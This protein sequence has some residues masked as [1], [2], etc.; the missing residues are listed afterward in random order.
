MLM[1][2]NR[3]IKKLGHGL[4]II[5]LL[6]FAI[7]LPV[8]AESIPTYTEEQKSDAT[9][10]VKKQLIDRNTSFSLILDLGDKEINLSDNEVTQLKSVGTDDNRFNSMVSRMVDSHLDEV[11]FGWTL[12]SAAT[13]HTGICREG[14]Y[15]KNSING[16][17][18]YTYSKS[19]TITSDCKKIT[20]DS[21]VFNFYFD[22]YTT[23]AEE[24]TFETRAAEVNSNL[25]VSKPSKL[26]DYEK[27]CNIYNYITKNVAY[28]TANVNNDSYKIK[29]SAYAA[30]VNKT[31]VCQGYAS[32]FYYMALDAGLDCRI[33]KGFSKNSKGINEFHAWNLVKIENNYY[34]VDATWDSGREEYKY[35][36]EGKKSNNY[37]DHIL[38][39]LDV[40]SEGNDYEN[41]EN[42]YTIPD[43]SYYSGKT[44]TE[45][46][47]ATVTIKNATYDNGICNADVTV[48][49]NGKTLVRGIDYRVEFVEYTHEAGKTEGI[50][51]VNIT[52]IGMYQS[53]MGNIECK[54]V[55]KSAS[56]S[57]TGKNDENKT[58]TTTDTTTKTT[59]KTTDESTTKSSTDTA[60]KNEE[61]KAS[62]N[63]TTKTV[64]KVNDSNII[65][66]TF[67]QEIKKGYTLSIGQYKYKVTKAGKK[68]TLRFLGSKT[69]SKMVTVPDA[70]NIDGVEY[71]VTEI[72][73]KAF[74]GNTKMTTL[75]VGKNVKKIGS[76][77]FYG[78]K[79]L[80]KITIRSKSLK[81]VGSKAFKNIKNKAKIIVPKGKLTKYKKLLKKKGVS[82][83]A[84]FTT[85]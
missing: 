64:A 47:N 41:P 39:G 67:D 61:N 15:L 42:I 35:F 17:Y 68:G 16:E 49:M 1:E 40:M 65:Y 63:E 30:L 76:K 70:V 84:K 27:V 55:D 36:L 22:Y 11:N 37:S 81:S 31:A 78:C 57:Q 52:G 26:S 66:A 14:D 34:Y 43:D 45:L 82:N 24:K 12:L 5:I 29:Q 69:K 56:A 83:K 23:S 74:K 73:S 10:Y 51:K 53:T 7:T 59:T 60:S 58:D 38:S 8:H 50:C 79:K 62:Q 25:G 54:M 72:Y 71:K 2:S 9:N 80:S 44:K 28:D 19:M 46:K 13:E 75:V 33:V 20:V 18:G 85:K 3:S 4:L 77:A 21:V 32:L 6:V 48:V